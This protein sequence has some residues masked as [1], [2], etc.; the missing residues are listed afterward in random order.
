MIDEEIL[1]RI[2]GVVHKLW[3]IE[4]FVGGGG[5]RTEVHGDE[6]DVQSMG[7]R[8]EMVDGRE[9]GFSEE[10]EGTPMLYNFERLGMKE[11]WP[12]VRVPNEQKEGRCASFLFDQNK[13]QV[14]DDVVLNRPV[15]SGHVDAQHTTFWGECSDV[16]LD[17][18][19]NFGAGHQKGSKPLAL[20]GPP[21]P[22]LLDFPP[23]RKANSNGP[24]PV[25]S[26]SPSKSLVNKYTLNGPSVAAVSDSILF[27]SKVDSA[28]KG[29]H[30]VN[31]H[32]RFKD[33]SDCSD[34][35]N[36]IEDFVNEEER[37]LKLKK[38]LRLRKQSAGSKG[39]KGALVN[40][41]TP[42][43]SGINLITHDNIEVIPET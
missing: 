28:V 37:L 30:L 12:I 6:D 18:D 10:G 11:V 13:R 1:I 4:E 7:S 19:G 35:S 3:V 17:M 43:P 34:L 32:I 21:F 20:V 16:Q 33:D 39:R 36:S 15:G 31:S 14:L 9:R 29:V 23:L 41:A 40:S 25:L 5:W 8:E 27:T 38:K 26:L 2:M 22:S 24:R 42:P